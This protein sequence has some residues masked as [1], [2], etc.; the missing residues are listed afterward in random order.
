MNRSG[1]RTSDGLPS[2]LLRYL[3]NNYKAGDRLPAIQELADELGI[4][5]GKLREQLEV[6]RTM[7]LIEVRP[8]TGMRVLPYSPDKILQLSLLYSLAVDPSY[9]E[10]FGVLRNHV[11]AA[12][13]YEAVALLN[14]E[15]KANL[16][17]IMEQAW[18]KLNAGHFPHEE[19]RALHLTLFSRLEN[20]FVLGLLTTYWVGYEAVGL[21]VYADYQYLKEVWNYHQE[22]VDAVISGNYTRGYEALIEH[23]GL[24]QNRSEVSRTRLRNSP[25]RVQFEPD[26][27]SFRDKPSKDKE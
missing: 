16:V 27:A 22:M 3:A 15:D 11:E 6:A 23:T 9:F 25:T 1:S 24:L 7:G 20:Q 4:S 14:G 8:K 2:R 21:D 10:D 5:T 12:F 13:W 19:H 18:N 17:E 26:P